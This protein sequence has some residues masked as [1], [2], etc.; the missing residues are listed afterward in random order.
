[1]KTSMLRLFCT[2]TLAVF[3]AIMIDCAASEEDTEG[4]LEP[5]DVGESVVLPHIYFDFNKA[6][7]KP[8]SFPELGK[9]VKLMVKYPSLK[10]EISGHTDSVGTDAANMKL[11]QDRAASVVKYLMDKGVS[12]SRLNAKGYGKSRPI[13]SNATEEGR[14]MNRRIEF[15]VLAK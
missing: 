9:V 1:M 3:A 15:T 6:T 5:V 13:E 7:L 8:E 10:I 14:A 11:S 2:F 12:K 4:E